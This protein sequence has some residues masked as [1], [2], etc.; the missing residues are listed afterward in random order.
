MS[1]VVHLHF[2]RRTHRGDAPRGGRG[3]WAAGRGVRL[4]GSPRRCPR[5]RW[6]ALWQ[7]VRDGPA[8]PPRPPE[9]RAAGCPAAPAVRPLGAR[10]LHPRTRPAAR[11]P[12]PAGS[13]GDAPMRGWSSPRARWPSSGSRR[14]WWPTAW[15]RLPSRR[16]RTVRG[17]GRRWA[18]AVSAVLG[19]VGR[20]RPRRGRDL[21][22]AWRALGAAASRVAS[23]AGRARR[24]RR[25]RRHAERRFHRAAGCSAQADPTSPRCYQGL[26]VLV[27]PSRQGDLPGWW[28]SR[29]W[30][31]AAAWWRPRSSM[32]APALVEHGGPGF[33][34]PPG[35]VASAGGR[36]GPA[37]WPDPPPAEAVGARGRGVGARSARAGSGLAGLAP[38]YARVERSG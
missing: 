20:I 38:M 22:E 15:M 6:R 3:A 33:L 32:H 8:R 28:C 37:R 30:P 9:P 12:G 25:M 2:H 4:R 24:P 10:G 29:R 23:G 11:R 34:Y 14:R 1:P 13:R 16:R 35:D 36:A 5:S 26:T 21:A 19:A 7:R 18:S 31:P 27:Q 17:P